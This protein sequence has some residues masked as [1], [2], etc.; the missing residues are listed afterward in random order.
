MRN[1]FPMDLRKI[2]LASILTLGLLAILGT[3]LVLYATP[4]GLGLLDDSI[5]YIAGARSILDG[6]GY[7]AAWL[8][9]NKPVT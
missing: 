2:P 4:Q 1:N 7:R 5:A 9:S 6:D 8:A 3:F